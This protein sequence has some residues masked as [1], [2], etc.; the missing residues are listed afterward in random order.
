MDENQLA[1]RVLDHCFEIHRELGPGLFE[2]IYEEILAHELIQSG[3]AFERQVPIPVRYR[4]HVFG[5]GFRADMIVERRIILELKSVEF[6]LPVHGK[7]GLS[8]L[9]LLDLRLGLLIN[10][11]SALLHQGITRIAHKL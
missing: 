10:F 2:S 11:N 6:I 9:R 3:I 4:G 1:T 7:Q 8:Y 5:I